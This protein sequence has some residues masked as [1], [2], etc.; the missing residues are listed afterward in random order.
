VLRDFLET[1]Q[2]ARIEDADWGAII[3]KR[4]PRSRRMRKAA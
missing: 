1:T 4:S 3:A 2:P